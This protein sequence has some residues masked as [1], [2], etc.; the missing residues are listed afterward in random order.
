MC[1]HA[2]SVA[3][4]TARMVLWKCCHKHPKV[5][6]LGSAALRNASSRRGPR[7]RSD[8]RCVARCVYLG[9]PRRRL[10][11]PLYHRLYRLPNLIRH[12]YFP[13]TIKRLRHT[14]SR[15]V[16]AVTTVDF[17]NKSPPEE[18]AHRGDSAPYCPCSGCAPTQTTT[19][20]RIIII[21]MNILI[22]MCHWYERRN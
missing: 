15:N 7:D 22:S 8:E 18:K 19:A 1:S 12:C 3:P 4:N 11:H 10:V 14:A 2:Y 21:H 16:S 9:S 5:E 17:Q 20:T 6:V 13:H